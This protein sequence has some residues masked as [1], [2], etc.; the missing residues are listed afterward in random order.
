MSLKTDARFLH[1]SNGTTIYPE[2]TGDHR[3]PHV[4]LLHGFLLSGCIYDD[5]CAD[6][7]PLETLYIVDL[8][9]FSRCPLRRH[10]RS[11][12]PTTP[13]AHQSK[14]FADDFKTVMD[15]VGL[16]TPVLVGWSMGATVVTDMA[17]HL[18][19][20]TL[21]GVPSTGEIAGEMLPPTLGA[22]LAGLLSTD[23]VSPFHAASA[24][25]ADSLFVRPDTIP[26]ALKCVYMGHIMTPDLINLSLT[27]PMDVQPLLNAGMDG[28]PLLLI[29]GTAD[30]HRVGSLKSSEEVMRPHF[31]NFECVWLEGRGHALHYE[32]P[33]D[34]VRLLI[35]F[36]QRM[37]GKVSNLF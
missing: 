25:F 36:I 15:A 33:E 23:D 35:E 31:K 4:V 19:P 10:G 12:K 7:Q 29:E 1:S 6:V 3:N 30:A 22:T 28:L 26:Y 13:G 11:G 24:M 20:A 16:E 5:L 2:A 21:S 8:F 27:R 9:S 14:M 17:A 32:C 37:A 34:I 18:P